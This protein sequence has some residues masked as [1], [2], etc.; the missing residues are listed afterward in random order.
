[1]RCAGK[2]VQYKNTMCLERFYDTN[3]HLLPNDRWCKNFQFSCNVQVKTKKNWTLGNCLTYLN[4]SP[5][6]LD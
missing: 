1:M 3:D 6:S 5:L 4:N 2:K